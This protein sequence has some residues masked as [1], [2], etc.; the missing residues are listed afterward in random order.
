MNA[1]YTKWMKDATE[2]QKK[3]Y[4]MMAAAHSASL[5]NNGGVIPSDIYIVSDIDNDKYINLLTS[6]GVNIINCSISVTFLSC[7]GA[8]GLSI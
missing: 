3:R 6:V 1:K 5:I 2:Q 4:P 7:S 8:S